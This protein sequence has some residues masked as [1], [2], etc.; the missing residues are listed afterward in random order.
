MTQ[1]HPPQ[2]LT[3]L[4]QSMDPLPAIP[5][6][7]QPSILS[8]LAL[9]VALIAL[10]VAVVTM[11]KPGPS[12]TVPAAPSAPAA[13]TYTDAQIAAAKTQTCTAAQRSIAGVRVATNR[14]GPIG[15]EDIQ[16]QI[17]AAT[18]RI[19]LLNAATNLPA[20]VTEP[21]PA[22]L[23]K[24]AMDLA[25]A[26]RDAVSAALTEGTSSAAPDGTYDKAGDAFNVAS[27]EVEQLC[28]Q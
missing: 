7:R 16:G 10:I 26:A 11:V 18:A 14:P 5:T 27:K 15:P 22:E 25:A 21:T 4:P 20:Q 13:P 6:R 2:S 12:Q 17:N 9:I 23:K 1:I 8:A 3:Q 19:A 28:R 24:S